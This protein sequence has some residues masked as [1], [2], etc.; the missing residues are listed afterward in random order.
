M[1]LIKL[2]NWENGDVFWLSSLHIVRVQIQ[3]PGRTVIFYY[4]PEPKAISV[5]ETPQRIARMINEAG[6]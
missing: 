2:T 3:P 4:D 6:E 1:K 5:K